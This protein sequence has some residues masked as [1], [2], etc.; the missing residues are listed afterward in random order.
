MVISDLNY[1]EVIS[2]TVSVQGGNLASTTGT[3]TFTG[4][5]NNNFALGVTTPSLGSGNFASSTVDAE[6]TNPFFP[7]IP[8][9]SFTKADQQDLVTL[10]GGSSSFASGVAAIQAI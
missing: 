1:F 8:A 6:A 5:S 2:E 4:N 9:N 7:F 3:V 10:G